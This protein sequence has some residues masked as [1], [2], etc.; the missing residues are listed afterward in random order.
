MGGCTSS[1][2]RT[3]KP[4]KSLRRHSK[5]IRRPEKLKKKKKKKTN[6]AGDPPVDTTVTCR[7]VSSDS[8][9]PV[10][11][12]TSQSAANVDEPWFDSVSSM[13]DS[14]SD[15]D[16][17][18]V[19]GDDDPNRD[20]DVSFLDNI[21]RETSPTNKLGR[22]YSSYNGD[23]NQAPIWNPDAPQ[24]FRSASFHDNITNTSNSGSQNLTGKPTV[25]K[26]AVKKTD[27]NGTRA[28][29]KFFYRPR[30]GF[31]IPCSTDEK[32]TPGCWSAINPSNFTLRSENYFKYFIKFPINYK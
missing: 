32:P 1:P 23:K 9:E 8:V 25:I 16:F 10:D 29:E 27:H 7:E 11:L 20:D 19:N 2:A 12:H 21:N 22:S 5:K 4:M 26:L 24:L 30:A 28:T 31:L 14:E 6:D 17:S 15:D 18:S 13:E 3:I